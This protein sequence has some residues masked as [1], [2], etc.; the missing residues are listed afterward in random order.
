MGN[1]IGGEIE[2]IESRTIVLYA[3]HLPDGFMDHLDATER[4]FEIRDFTAGQLETIQ[5]EI[6]NGDVDLLIRFPENFETLIQ[7]YADPDYVVPEIM[8]YYN[9]GEMNSSN[10]YS[11]VSGALQN[12]RNT[13]TYDRF[14]DDIYVFVVDATNEDHIIMDEAKATG[15]SFASLLPM[16]ILMFLFSGAM[17]IGPDSIAGEKERGTI[18]TLLVTPIRRRDVAIGKV[19]SLSI[20][21]LMSAASSFV[22]ILLSLPKL[23]QGENLNTNIYGFGDYVAIL[24]VLLATVLFIVGIVSVV[25]AYAKSIKEA[26]ML[27]LPLYFIAIIIGVTTMF[28]NGDTM[29]NPLLYAIPLYNSVHMLIGILTFEIDMMN[30]AIMVASN[31]VYVVVL[32]F[33]MN[34][35]FESERV[36]FSK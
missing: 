29:T 26:S 18:A 30:F 1:V 34:K 19:L 23:M 11:V 16:L 15:Q 36:M 28:N 33:V 2:E 7:D 21:A 8:T 27:V 10:A 5:E 13:I 14:G 17:S 24:V 35:L 4:T 6:L 20:V 3:E 32:V 25:S 9:P 31:L 22:G 12:Y